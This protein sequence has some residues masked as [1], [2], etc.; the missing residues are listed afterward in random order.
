ML[1]E[2]EGSHQIKEEMFKKVE[3]ATLEKIKKDAQGQLRTFD[4]WYHKNS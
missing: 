4:E 1:D 3:T 2:I